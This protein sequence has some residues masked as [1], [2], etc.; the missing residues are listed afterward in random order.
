MTDTLAATVGL[1]YFEDSIDRQDQ[2]VLFSDLFGPPEN[3][4][5]SFSD[6]S[7]RFNVAWTPSDD[8]LVYATASR[9]F[10]SGNTQAAISLATAAIFGADLP[11]EIDPEKVWN[12]ELG[13]K[14]TLLDNRLTLDG[15][16]YYLDYSNLQSQISLNQFLFGTVNSG[17]VNGLGFEFSSNFQATDNL[18]LTFTGNVNETEYAET[19]VDGVGNI[20]F[21]DGQ[22][23]TG[24]PD[25]TLTGAIDYQRQLTKDWRGVLRASVEYNEARQ[26]I[27]F[28]APPADPAFVPFLMP[29]PNDVDGVFTD[30]VINGSFDAITGEENARV[31]LRVGIENDQFG[32]YAFAENL[33][34]DDN[35]ISPNA[36]FLGA[37]GGFASRYR[38]RTIGVNLSASF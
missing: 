25:L 7:P 13:S 23:V 11:I 26:A 36:T 30:D 12:Y 3:I 4:S 16:L 6:V 17:S 18:S 5:N 28:T 31:N 15:A 9:G 24:V 38:P 19:I 10:R 35:A 2:D 8:V 14:L 37:F 21:A 33:S 29:L 1:R 27:V 20:V 32:I 34:N 22:P